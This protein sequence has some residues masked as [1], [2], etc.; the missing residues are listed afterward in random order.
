MPT[1]RRTIGNLWSARADTDPRPIGARR[2]VLLAAGPRLQAVLLALVTLGP[3]QGFTQDSNVRHPISYIEERLRAADLQ[4]LDV[5]A[6][7]DPGFVERSRRLTLGGSDGEPPMEAHWKPVAPPG[8]GFNNEPRYALAAYRFQTM[9]LEEPEYVVPP[10]VLRAMSV[11]EYRNLQFAG[12][13]TIRGTQSVLFLL[14]YWIQNLA[15]IA[16]DPN[17]PALFRL[18]ERSARHFANANIFTHLIDHKDANPGNVVVSMDVANRRVFSV[19]NDVAFR[20]AEP[21]HDKGDRWRRLHVN[22]LPSATIERLRT[23]T[24]EQLDRELGVVAEFAIVD[25]TLVPVEPGRNLSPGRGLR[26]TAQRV[27]FGLTTR[28]I[29]E[30]ERRIRNLLAQVDR[31]RLQTF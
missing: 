24:R 12:G 29:S 9:F 2:L 16:E 11:E 20:S 27:Q 26:V 4:I 13:P 5:A 21:D 25:R 10:T 18:D 6:A 31:G 22:R 1:I 17:N 15:S 3:V 23:I 7:R 19:D 30:L 8:E 14:T 28:E